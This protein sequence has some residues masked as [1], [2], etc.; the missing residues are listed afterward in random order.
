MYSCLNLNTGGLL[1]SFNHISDCTSKGFKQAMEHF[2]HIF[3]GAI[4]IC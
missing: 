3:G 2:K 1:E 4:K